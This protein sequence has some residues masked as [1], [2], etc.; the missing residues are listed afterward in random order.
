MN[1]E[2]NKRTREALK[3][4]ERFIRGFEGDEMQEGIDSLLQTIRAAIRHEGKRMDAISLAASVL[5]GCLW[6]WDKDD[7]ADA[8]D[9]GDQ[10]R[11]AVKMLNSL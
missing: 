5:Q 4:A 10:M 2:A 6:R 3:A 1:D 8:P 9:L 7:E 11:Q